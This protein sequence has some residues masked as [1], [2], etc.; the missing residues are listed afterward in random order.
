MIATMFITR[1]SITIIMSGGSGIAVGMMGVLMMVMARGSA[2]DRV[3]VHSTPNLR[4]AREAEGAI[5]GITMALEPC[6]PNLSPVLQYNFNLRA[7]RG[8]LVHHSDQR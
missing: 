1:S 4:Y 3:L 5:D 8:Y 6:R 2:E 7:P